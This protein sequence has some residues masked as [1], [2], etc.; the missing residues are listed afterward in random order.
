MSQEPPI[1]EAHRMLSAPRRMHLLEA[2]YIHGPMVRSDLVEHVAAAEN[3]KDVEELEKEELNRVQ[4]TLLQDHLPPLAEF[5]FIVWDYDDSE[6][7]EVPNGSDAV[8]LGPHSHLVL[9]VHKDINKD[10][11]PQWLAKRLEESSE[12]RI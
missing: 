8:A 1:Y 6:D 2:L 9:D 11:G 10:D 7:S 4:S 5:G 12:R 3:E